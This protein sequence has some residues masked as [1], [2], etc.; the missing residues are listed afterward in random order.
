[1]ATAD[2]FGTKGKPTQKGIRS[3]KMAFFSKKRQGADFDFRCFMDPLYAA[4]VSVLAGEGMA[5]MVGAA[6]GGTGIL[7]SIYADG[8]RLKVYC[9][10]ADQFT[11]W[12]HDVLETFA[13]SSEDVYA[14]W[15]LPRREQ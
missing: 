14:A 9:N 5:L 8:E 11:S 13:S 6:Q 7:M 2:K 1:M 4:A 15:G 12:C 3:E 10:D